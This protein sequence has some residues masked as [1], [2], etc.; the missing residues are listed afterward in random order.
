MVLFS[1]S[2]DRLMPA[3]YETIG[4]TYIVTR[5]PDER[6][7]AQIVAA[8]ADAATV[9]NVGAGAGNY[10]PT[11]RDVFALDPSVTMLGQRRSGTG[12]ATC[13]VA[14]ALP[15]RDSCFD[16][17]MGTFTLH[18]WRDLAAGLREVRRVAPLQM[19]LMY[20]PA[21]AKSMW[22]IEYFHEILDLPHEKRAPSVYTLRAY[23][24][25]VDVQ[26]VPVPADCTDGFGGAFWARPEM[27]LDPTVQAG[28]SMLAVLEPL[29]RAAGTERLRT[30]IGSGDWDARFGQLRTQESV[31]LGY[32]LVI[33]RS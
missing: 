21:F 12:H 28:M 14:E 9:L 1:S 25:V 29:V 17:V 24:N 22:I 10:E 20:E 3:L 27:Y 13:G 5:Q 6:I 33:S 23:L 8:L 15:F 26:I 7:A 31:D 30:S 4:Q 32:R 11:D 18:H 16:A 19:F 2:D